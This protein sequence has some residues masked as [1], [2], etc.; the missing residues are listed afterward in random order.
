MDLTQHHHI[1]MQRPS[2]AQR[3]PCIRK[4]RFRCPHGPEDDRQACLLK[5]C[6]APTEGK[7]LR[8]ETTKW[9]CKAHFTVRHLGDEY[10]SKDGTPVL[11]IYYT[12]TD[13]GP[14]PTSKKSRVSTLVSNN[15][16]VG[17]P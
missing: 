1:S 16:Y 17:Y 8:V 2:K 3:P 7:R 6:Q 11:G 10:T 13:H 14:H 5:A 4:E 9:G 15:L 12:I